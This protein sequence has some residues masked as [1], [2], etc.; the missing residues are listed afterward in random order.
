MNRDDLGDRMKQYEAVPKNF[1]IRRVPVIIRLDGKNFHSFTHSFRKPFDPLLISA[2]QSTMK[3][4]CENIQGCVFG[5]TQS[6]E[7]TLVLTDY[8]TIDTAAWFDY[9]V[10]KMVS[11]A[12]SMA[13]LAFNRFF[14]DAVTGWQNRR[15]IELRYD[16][17]ERDYCETMK[18]AIEKGAMFDARAFNLPHE[19]VVNCLIW[20]QNDA[21]RN[22][23]QMA[24]HAVFSHKQM[25][26]KSNAEIQDMLVTQKGINWNDYPVPCKRGSACYRIQTTD[27]MK[28]PNPNGDGKDIVVMRNPWI[29]DENIPVFTK[30]RMFVQRHI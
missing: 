10:Q 3:Y 14:A 15:M 24:G 20:R 9:N 19:E 4:L 5:Y 2:M 6:D 28:D 1:L 27:T 8:A 17:W 22:S 18:K 25:Q 11:I 23:I 16:R 29:I 7:I 12:A 26:G 13:T 30:D 21:T